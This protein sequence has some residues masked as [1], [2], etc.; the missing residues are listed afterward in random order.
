[1]TNSP[2]ELGTTMVKA[3]RNATAGRR[4]LAPGRMLTPV[5]LGKNN[6]GGKDAS[7]KLE[8]VC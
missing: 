7:W 6:G 3:V 8:G 1:M 5:V 4:G 2:A